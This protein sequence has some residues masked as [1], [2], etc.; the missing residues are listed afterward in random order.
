MRRQHERELARWLYRHYSVLS[1]AL[2]EAA[3]ARRR[4]A[5]YVA[6]RGDKEEFLAEADEYRRLTGE[7]ARMM[8]RRMEG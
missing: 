7:L 5:H 3:E 1:A 2:F 6:D 8:L 4:A